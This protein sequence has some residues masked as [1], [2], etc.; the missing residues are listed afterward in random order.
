[1]LIDFRNVFRTPSN[2]SQGAFF[3][4]VIHWLKAVHNFGK[5]FIID[6]WQ[7]PEY[8]SDWYIG[9]FYQYILLSVVFM[10]LVQVLNFQVFFINFTYLDS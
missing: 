5:K 1:M 6:V 8:S 9:V 4:I 10:I 7:G 2:I 3:A